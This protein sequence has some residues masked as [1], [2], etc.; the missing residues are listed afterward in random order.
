MVYLRKH[1][2]GNLG[3][4]IPLICCF[5][6]IFTGLIRNPQRCLPDYGTI[7]G[8]LFYFVIPDLIRDPHTNCLLSLC[9]SGLDPESTAVFITENLI[10]VDFWILVSSTRMT[11]IVS[12]KYFSGPRVKHGATNKIGPLISLMANDP[13]PVILYVSSSRT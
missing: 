3:L 4:T 9:H 1:I 13:T 11:K 2:I 10:A 6:I 8:D 5:F 7:S 12:G